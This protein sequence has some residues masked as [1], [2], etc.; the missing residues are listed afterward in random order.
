MS[1]F[2]KISNEKKIKGMKNEYM[3]AAFMTANNYFISWK[4]EDN[5]PY[6]F[7]ATHRTTGKTRLIDAK[8]VAFRKTWRPGTRIC[9]VLSKYQKQLGVEILYVYEDG[10]CDFHGKK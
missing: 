2:S 6:D 7:A 10:K 8:T 4:Q 9:R 1:D 3:A 5:A